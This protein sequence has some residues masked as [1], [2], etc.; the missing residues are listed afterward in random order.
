MVS[1]IKVAPDTKTDI[2]A[3]DARFTEGGEAR[4]TENGESRITE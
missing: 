2:G 3:I 1:L 4:I